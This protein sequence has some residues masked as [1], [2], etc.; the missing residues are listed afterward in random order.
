MRLDEQ[1]TTKPGTSPKEKAD[2]KR[3]LAEVLKAIRAG[4]EKAAAELKILR[5]PPGFKPHW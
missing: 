1:M 5:S 4:N 2:V 3:H